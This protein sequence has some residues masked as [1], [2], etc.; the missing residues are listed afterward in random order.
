MKIEVKT[1]TAWY[2]ITSENDRTYRAVMDELINPAATENIIDHLICEKESSELSIQSDE[3]AINTYPNNSSIVSTR[4]RTKAREEIRLKELTAKIDAYR[5]EA[6][7]QKGD[8][9]IL[10]GAIELDM[11]LT[12]VNSKG[13]K[14][15]T[16]PV[17]YLKIE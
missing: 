12:L 7:L 15:I 3:R 2:S 14:T 9:F 17:T 10:E 13:D 8:V 1:K 16:M 11:P 4:S 6:K 5:A